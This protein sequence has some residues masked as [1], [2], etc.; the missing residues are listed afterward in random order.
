VTRREE[1]PERGSRKAKDGD[2]RMDPQS[3]IDRAMSLWVVTQ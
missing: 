3:E 2:K 1:N